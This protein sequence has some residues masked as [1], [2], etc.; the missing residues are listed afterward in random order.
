MK[1]KSNTNV[2][3]G[4][5]LMLDMYNCAPEILNDRELVLQI[6]QTLPAKLDMRILLD[7]AVTFAQPNGKRDPGGWSGFVMIQESHIS[8][9]TFIKRR[10]VTIDI[11]SCREFDTQFAIDYFKKM[12]KTENIDCIVE[13]RGRSYPDED[14][15]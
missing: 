9:H 15:E 12:F 8:I 14:I 10:F 6:L 2:P 4:W 5:H 3:F 1:T 7:P 11:Y 13:K